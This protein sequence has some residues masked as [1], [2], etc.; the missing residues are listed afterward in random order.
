MELSI[1]AMDMNLDS[2]IRTKEAEKMQRI[3][4]NLSPEYAEKA[5]KAAIDFESMMIKQMLSSMTQSLDNEGFFGSQ[6]GSS[7]YQD[8]FIGSISE[9]IA[10]TQSFG[11]AKQILSQINPDAIEHLDKAKLPSSR[12]LSG[13]PEPQSTTQKN[14]ETKNINKPQ[15]IAQPKTLIGRLQSYEPIIKQASEKYNVDEN[16]IKAVIA[17]ESYA[18][19]QAVSSAG[20]KGLMQ[21]MDGTA[22]E[23]GVNDSFDPRENIMGGT[24]YLKQMLDRFGDTETALAAYNAGPGNVRKYQ[25]IPPFRET[26]NYIKR[27]LDY[28]SNFTE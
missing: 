18:N 13:V 23:L 3:Q 1:K 12:R 4:E 7:F 11:L 17:Q 20:A 21:L 14:F 26:R 2:S 8:M 9:N 24:R 25:G 15:L 6:A 22:K 16:L 10:S 27:V 19:P 28:F 5:A